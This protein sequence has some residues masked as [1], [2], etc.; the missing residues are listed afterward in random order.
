MGQSSSRRKIDESA[1]DGIDD[2][3]VEQ[4]KVVENQFEHYEQSK[5]M[6]IW[7]K[8]DGF[9]PSVPS[10]QDEGGTNLLNIF[11]AKSGKVRPMR[12]ATIQTGLFIQIPENARG[13]LFP[14]T[15]YKLTQKEGLEW[16][17]PVQEDDFPS[18]ASPVLILNPPLFPGIE[19]PEELCIQLYNLH[20][21]STLVWSINTPIA[22]IGLTCSARMLFM[23]LDT[24]NWESE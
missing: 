9:V 17:R 13:D 20:P 8:S 11:P 21:T 1:I 10:V 6:Q 7:Y 14:A 24:V 12:I 23:S 16:E 22:R 4:G 15:A 19:S 3:D 18:M 5:P 2:L